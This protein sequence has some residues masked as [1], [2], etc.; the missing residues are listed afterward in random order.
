MYREP[1][2]CGTFGYLL[3]TSFLTVATEV[4]TSALQAMLP[5]TGRVLASVLSSLFWG[6]SH[7]TSLVV[8]YKWGSSCICFLPKAAGLFLHLPPSQ[9]CWLDYRSVLMGSSL[10]HV[11]ASGCQVWKQTE[12][13]W[14]KPF[15]TVLVF[16]STP[17]SRHVTDTWSRGHRGRVTT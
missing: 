10:T 17:K 16:A 4:G 5:H 2:S 14:L 11:F 12:T 8:R 13:V 6:A 9:G 15:Q 3:L 7:W 1:G